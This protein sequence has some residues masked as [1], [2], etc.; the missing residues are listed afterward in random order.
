MQKT[1]FDFLGFCNPGFG[2]CNNNVLCWPAGR[3][4][5][6]KMET[7]LS[8]LHRINTD[9]KKVI[10]AFQDGPKI[11]LWQEFSFAVGQTVHLM[12]KNTDEKEKTGKVWRL[13]RFRIDGF[14]SDKI[15]WIEE[16]R[17]FKP[18]EGKEYTYSAPRISWEGGVLNLEEVSNLLNNSK[19]KELAPGQ[20]DRYFRKYIFG[21]VMQQPGQEELNVKFYLNEFLKFE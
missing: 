14:S 1:S 10:T 16:E 13:H 3:A 17:K 2:P 21:L 5:P 4:K 9:K 18:V 7:L 19:F 6:L 11:Q 12:D 8:F 20:F 15:T